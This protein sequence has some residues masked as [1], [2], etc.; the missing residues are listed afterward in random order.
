M[1]KRGA[2]VALKICGGVWE[3]GEG[4]RKV[5]RKWNVLLDLVHLVH[6]DTQ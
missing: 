1:G 6:S 2:E 3:Y 5:P 4:N